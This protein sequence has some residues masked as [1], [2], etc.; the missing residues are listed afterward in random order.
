MYSMAMIDV[1]LVVR[2]YRCFGD[3]P[4]HLRIA[5]GFT[6][7]VGTNN[8][9][10]SSLL[11]L[12]YE[13]RPLFGLLADPT[14]GGGGHLSRGTGAGAWWYPTLL[15]G[16]RIFR[17][18]AQRDIEI[19]IVVRDGPLGAFTYRGQQVLVGL[20]YRQTDNVTTPTIR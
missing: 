16:E 9:G 3:E 17:A 11:R 14:S 8:S 18:G 19:K 20:T 1:E 13:I 5:D 2:N 10:K 7:L 15:A 4:V 6:A 12:L